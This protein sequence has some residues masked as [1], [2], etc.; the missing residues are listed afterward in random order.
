MILLGW[1]LVLLL[2]ALWSGL[3]WAGTALLAVVLDKAGAM[4]AG[5]WSLPE[6]VAAWLPPWAAEWLAGTLENLT[7]QLQWL[8]GL[9]PSLS[10]GAV[11]VGWLVWGLGALAL[12]AAGLAV[13]VGV[14]LWRKSVASTRPSLVTP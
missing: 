11:W 6:P 14:A 7:P 9:L 8:A 1:A 10:G 2:L 3:V 4:G 5:D 13:H 12:L